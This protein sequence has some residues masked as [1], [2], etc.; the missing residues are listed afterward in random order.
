MLRD[1]LV[2]LH[3]PLVVAAL[4]LV[5]VAAM[6]SDRASRREGGRD[7]PWWSGLIL[8]VAVPIQRMVAAPVDLAGDLWGRYVDLLDLRD[9]NAGL[10]AR[11]NAL[12]EENLQLREA[13]VASGRLQR[14]AEMRAAFEL[15][16][17]PA[18]VAGQD[19]SPWFRSVLLDR[20]QRHGVRAGMPVINDEGVVGL[21]T[22]TS[23]GASQIMLLLDRQSAIDAVVQRTR[24]QGIVRGVGRG[25]LVFEFAA[26]DADVRVGDVVI[27]SG[28][29]GVYPKGLRVGSV[30]ALPEAGSRLLRAAELEAAV[31]FGRLEQVFVLLWR[32]PTLELLFPAPPGA[33][34]EAE[35]RADAAPPPP[36]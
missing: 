12:E 11:V 31:E 29:G 7:H 4:V 1:L 20:G 13:L 10:Q 19:V 3:V 32:S 5:C 9:E 34:G 6:L 25:E 18:Q 8:E 23:T 35:T 17:L 22:D 15:P 33:S 2:K 27:T 36:P 16:M 14:I 24:T 21:V 28:L 26:R 30:S